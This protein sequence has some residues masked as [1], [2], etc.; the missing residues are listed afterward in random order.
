M[1]Q[2]VRV[3]VDCFPSFFATLP[4]CGYALVFRI[5]M[6]RKILVALENSRSDQTLLPHIGKLAHQLGSELLLVHVA[7]GWVARNFNQLKLAES[8][9][10]KEDRAYLETTAA[11]LRSEGLKV[12]TLLALGDPPTEILRASETENCDLIAMT[13]HGHRLIGDLFFGSAIHTVRHKATVPL[14]IL[15]AQ[16]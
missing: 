9:E 15:R 11:K 5:A 3:G 8:D 13:S 6:Y 2:S 16:Q 14:L 1:R 10:M 12:A 7:D 4:L